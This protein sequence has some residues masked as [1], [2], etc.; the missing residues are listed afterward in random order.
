MARRHL[1]EQLRGALQESDL[2]QEA[3]IKVE[4]GLSATLA[5]GAQQYR[6]WMRTILRR[7]GVDALRSSTPVTSTGL[8]GDQEERGLDQ[9]VAYAPSPSSEAAAR[10][11]Q[12]QLRHSMARLPAAQRQAL[13]LYLEDTA[14]VEIARQL[15]RTEASVASLVK[16]GLKFLRSGQR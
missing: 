2:V 4:R 3:L 10:E 13:E 16:R 7:V 8:Q 14:I 15:G 5:Q 11:Q 9:L 1:P 6:A 12:E